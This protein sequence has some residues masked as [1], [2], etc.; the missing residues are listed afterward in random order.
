MTQGGPIF[1]A[2]SG[3]ASTS[4]H[5]HH[6]SF[7]QWYLSRCPIAAGTASK[8]LLIP[9]F[10]Q[11][12]SSAPI[13]FYGILFILFAISPVW[14]NSTSYLAHAPG[15]GLGNIKALSEDLHHGLI[16]HLFLDLVASLASQSL[17]SSYS[18]SARM[19]M[20]CPQS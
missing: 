12:A 3:P 7:L 1:T 19:F 16:V 5:H 17:A 10:P 20:V 9:A 8:H 11:C 2:Y 4:M 15:L 18:L 6:L 14:P 13:Q